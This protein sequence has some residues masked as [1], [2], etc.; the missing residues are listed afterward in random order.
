MLFLVRERYLPLIKP[1]G[2]ANNPFGQR[3][4]KNASLDRRGAAFAPRV[5]ADYWQF[6]ATCVCADY[7][8]FRRVVLLATARGNAL[9]FASDP[10]GRGLG[11]AGQWSLRKPTPPNE[12]AATPSPS[13]LWI[14]RAR[15]T[16]SAFEVSVQTGLAAPGR[17]N[18]IAEPRVERRYPWRG[19]F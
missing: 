16:L 2:V 7:W 4:F 10:C 19:R 8:Q 17:G 12:G 5:C 1:G 13:T 18:T 3:R 11:W 15:E 6:C 9:V 14:P